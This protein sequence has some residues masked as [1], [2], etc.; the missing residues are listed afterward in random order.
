M[1]GYVCLTYHRVTDEPA[2]QA[3]PYTVRP[4]RF[5]AQM[6]WLARRSYRV[7]PL[8]EALRGVK[9][10]SIAL[11][12]DDG[13]ADFSTTVWPILQSYGFRAT[14]FAIAGRVGQY[15][16]WI[17]TQAVPL[18]GWEHLRTL[19]GEGMVIEAHGTNH[20]PLNTL[21]V[22]AIEADL[23]SSRQIIE[24]EIGIPP[25]GLAYPYGC[26]S[27]DVACT[28]R[29]VGFQW[30]CSARGGRNSSDTP[31]FKLRRTL[32]RGND[33]LLTFALKARTGYAQLVDWKMDV[34]R[35]P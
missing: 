4:D 33:T 1:R 30:G 12:F 13:Y 22:E 15:A 16:D 3:D 34:R 5:R 28:A 20:H 17:K 2:A 10:R 32:I 26:W 27:P 31:L 19:A 21:P 14:I 23:L 29:R 18:M 6:N 24:R 35:I 11:T 7:V 9:R 8:S 25:D